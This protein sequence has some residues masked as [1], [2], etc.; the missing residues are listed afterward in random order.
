MTQLRHDRPILKYLDNLTREIRKGQIFPAAGPPERPKGNN[1]PDRLTRSRDDA[2]YNR[3]LAEYESLPENS[4]M[5][6][7]SLISATVVISNARLNLLETLRTLNNPKRQAA[8]DEAFVSLCEASASFEEACQREVA[9]GNSPTRKWWAK[10]RVSL[11]QEWEP[12]EE[13]DQLIKDA[14]RR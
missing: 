3:V 2:S 11:G 9:E 1:I 4:Q 14:R 13:A 5:V 6:I 8:Y 10:L 12:F 7:G